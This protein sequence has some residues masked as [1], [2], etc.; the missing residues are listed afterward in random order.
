MA[1]QTATKSDEAKIH[2][3]KNLAK[4]SSELRDKR[5][6]ESVSLRKHKREQQVS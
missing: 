2:G 5:L 3:F 6:Q 1:D 4:D